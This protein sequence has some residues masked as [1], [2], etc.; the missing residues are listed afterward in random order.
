M[1]DE[2]Q[3]PDEAL[4]Y[5]SHLTVKVIRLNYAKQNMALGQAAFLGRHLGGVEKTKTSNP[6]MTN[7]HGSG[8]QA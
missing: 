4:G 3:H 1:V 7:H 6:K 5:G 8:R 2:R